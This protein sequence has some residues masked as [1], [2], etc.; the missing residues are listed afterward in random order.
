M[1]NRIRIGWAQR[2]ITPGRPVSLRGQFNL[3]IATRIQDPLTL[4]ALAL[5]NSDDY[6]VLVSV[7]ACGVD[8]E[9]LAEARTM[10][11]ERLPELDPTKL[12]VSATHTHTAPFA[13]GIGLQKDA[14]YIDAIRQRYPD[15]MSA[16]EYSEL[17]I[18]ALVGAVFEA[19]ESLADGYLG[20]GYSHAVV[21]ENR[22]VRYFDDR[23]QMYGSTAAAD[24][25][26]IEGH[27]DHSVNMLFT[28]DMEETL[29]GMLVNVA[30]PSQASESG[31]DFVS[32]DYWHDVRGELRSRYGDTLFVLPQC[33][34]AGDQSPHRLVAKAAEVR[35]LELKY[36]GGTERPLNAALRA[37]IARR[38]AVAVDDAEPAVRKDLHDEAALVH[39]SRVL[40]LDHWS[41]TDAEYATLREQVAEYEQQFAALGQSDVLDAQ[42]SS[43][44]SRIAWCRRAIDRYENP[45]SSIPSEVHVIRLGDIAFVT[46]PFE[47]YLDYGDRIKGRSPA[48]QT[49]IVQLAGGGSYLATERAAQGLSYGAVPPSCR[50]SPTGGQQIVDASVAT[51][52]GMF[53]DE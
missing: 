41:V 20:W 44:R 17:L 53:A 47:Y 27:V 9:I 19:W 34:A 40:E 26:H 28:Y 15:Y 2:D 42:Y 46:A 21:G 18:E 50:V 35:M 8:P 25:S 39:E 45:P 16:S 36:G 11:A 1:S 52:L 48:L 51:L 22:R 6:A 5:H 10:L 23:A 33:S 14:D 32:A 49:F 24:F 43:L 30:C 38:I 3:R 37:D 12:V 31:Q 7:D 4:T 29:T 13:G